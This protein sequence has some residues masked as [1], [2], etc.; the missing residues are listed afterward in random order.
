MHNNILFHL[1]I[2]IVCVVTLSGFA[3]SANMDALMDFSNAVIVVDMADMD[4]VVEN[5]ARVLIEEVEKRAGLRWK[6]ED[7]VPDT[8]AYVLITLAASDAID[9]E[10]FRVTLHRDNGPGLHIEAADARATLFG[11]GHLLRKGV[12]SNGVF[13]VSNDIVIETAPRYPLRGHQLGYRARGNT[14]AAWD[15][16]HYEQYIRELALFGANAIENIPNYGGEESPVHVMS[17]HDMNTHISEIC[18]Q[19]GLAFWMWIPADFD[20]A[21]EELRA[22][23]LRTHEET[24]RDSPRVDAVF[25]PG[26]DPGSNP[27]ELVLPFITE[28]APMLRRHHPH[29]MIWLS[30]Q[31]FREPWVEAFY[32]WLEDEDPREWFG[33]VVHGPG[34]PDLPETRERV[35][36]HYPIRHYPDITHIVRC[37]YPHNQL[38]PLFS[39]AITRQGVNPQPRHSR[40]I[41]NHFAPLTNGFLSYSDGAHDDVNKVVWTRLGWNPDESLREILMDYAR[42]FFRPDLADDGADAILGLE[43]NWEGAAMDNGGVTGTLRLWER[44]AEAMPDELS[45]PRA[46]WRLQMMLFR[47]TLDAYARHRLIYEQGLETQACEAILEH[48]DDPDRAMDVALTILEKAE[49]E[50]VQPHLRERII[51]MAK[52][53]CESIGLQSDVETYQ[54]HSPQRGGVLEYLDTPLNSRYWIEDEFERLRDSDDEEAVRRRLYEIA[55]WQQPGEGSF[56]DDLGNVGNSPNVLYTGG[57]SGHP[58]Q[59]RQPTPGYWA[60][61]GGRARFRYGWLHTMSNPEGLLYEHL[62]PGA[63]YLLRVAGYGDVKPRADGEPLTPT[64]YDTSEG[65]FKDFPVPQKYYA[66]GALTI[67][68]DELDERHLNWREWSRMAEVWLLKQ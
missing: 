35:P 3:A 9:A 19:Y 53:L 38:D 8:G 17:R 10:G 44:I 21:D 32:E 45:G 11:V 52:A 43:E 68:F 2:L 66:D 55:T 47:A 13:Y 54:I 1:F 39:I 40:F 15:R 51:T 48:H 31:G 61:D 29:A 4:A 46:N 24:Y 5:A 49:T 12:W 41:H 36:A 26:G 50:G 20:L 6:R 37:Q 34:S 59:H 62:D 22:E 65:G 63:D 58:M 18:Q 28:L 25:F 33:G 27:P 64:D 67:T 23:A 57:P 60:P 56:Y 14:Y 30:L 7:G 16:D 42:F